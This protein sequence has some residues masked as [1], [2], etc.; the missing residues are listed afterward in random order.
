MQIIAF[1]IGNEFFGVETQNV[2]NINDIMEI[3]KVPNSPAYI[4]GLINLRGN[5]I[6]L[7][8]LH[9]LLEAQVSEESQ[10]NIIILGIEEEQIGIMV[11]SVQ[12]VLEVDDKDIQKIEASKH[13]AYLKGI[14]NLDDKIITLIDINRILNP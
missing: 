9:L 14:V 8:D 6:S 1:K 10:N 11:D 4:K 5:I 13:Q 2:Q 7:V 12:E 3:T